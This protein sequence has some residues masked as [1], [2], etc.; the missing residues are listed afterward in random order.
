METDRQEIERQRKKRR[1]EARQEDT[2][3]DKQGTETTRKT[4]DEK[5]LRE[6]EKVREAEEEVK[7]RRRKL[8]SGLEESQQD[9]R[10]SLSPGLHH[11][12][13]FYPVS[14]YRHHIWQ[15]AV[16]WVDGVNPPGARELVPELDQGVVSL[17][18]AGA[19]TL[20]FPLALAFLKIKG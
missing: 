14:S 13:L 18:P 3:I 12:P 15:R 2:G 6:Q 19:E 9:V 4:E 17:W 10:A 20:L 1:G 16:K 7:L 8:G 5:R 11:T